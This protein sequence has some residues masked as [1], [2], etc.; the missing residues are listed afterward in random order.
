MTVL[1]FFEWLENTPGSVG[2]RES[3][4]TYPIIE[5]THVLSLCLF[6]G[7]I[8]MLDLRLV[9]VIFRRV[10]VSQVAGRLLPWAFAGFVV[11]V[12]S[13]VLLFYSGPVRASQNIFFRIKLVMLI[14]AGLNALIFH[15]TTYRRVAEWDLDP[16]APFKARAAGVFSLLMW[17]GVVVA[18]RMIAY[19][20]FD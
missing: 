11:S 1:R 20:W 4:W 16:V 14:L 10:P 9:G 13:G 19:N 2:I 15:M 17:A 6:L 18:G 8:V 5:T 7:M 12:I 3:I